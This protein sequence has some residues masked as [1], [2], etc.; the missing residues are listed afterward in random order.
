MLRSEDDSSASGFAGDLPQL[1]PEIADQSIQGDLPEADHDDLEEYKAYSALSQQ[2]D[3]VRYNSGVIPREFKVGDLI[4]KRVLF[5]GNARTSRDTF[6]EEF[7]GPFPVTRVYGYGAYQIRDQF[8]NHD[9]VHIDNL[10]P[11]PNR[12]QR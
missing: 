11:Y 5:R 6:S 10:Q 4:L 7:D 2:R 3:R 9:T 1:D 8:G 12:E